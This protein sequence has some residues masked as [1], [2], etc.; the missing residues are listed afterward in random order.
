MLAAVVWA[1]T[2][3]WLNRRVARASRRPAGPG[4]DGRFVALAFDRVVP[5]PD[6]KHLDRATLRSQFS[7]LADAGWQPVTLAE[8][9]AA[10]RGDGRL[11]AK[12][13]LLTFD[14]GYLATY[15]AVDPILRERRWPAVMFLRTDRQEHRDVSFLFWDRLRRMAQSGLWEIASG[16]PPPP[17]RT[18]PEAP[19]GAALIGSRLGIPSAPAWAPRGTEPLVACAC[20]EEKLARGG[21]PWLGFVDDPVGAN[22]PEASPFRIA[23]LRV[24]PL[25]T[26]DDLLHRA[27]V[28]VADATPDAT[29]TVWV[30][31]EGLIEAEGGVVRL[32]GQPRTDI[33][34]PAARWSDDWRLDAEVRVIRGEFW[35][36][37]PGAVPGREWRFGGVS[38]ALYVQDRSDGRPPEVLAKSD[39]F[40]VA[41]G[42]HVVSVVKRGQGISVTWDGRP[43]SPS[44]VALPTRWRG[45]V[46]L[47]GYGGDSGASMI[48][49]RLV[50]TPYPYHVQVVPSAPDAGD[51]A[52]WTQAASEIA[53]LSPP[54]A[55]IDG[56][57]VRE[58]GF[59]RDLFRILGRR[60][61]W[62]IVP[63][64]AI[65]GGAGPD[66]SAAAWLH[67]LPDRIA[68]EGWAGL[69]VDLRGVPREAAVR[70]EAA[71]RELGSHLR[72]AHRRLVVVAS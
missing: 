55:S 32:T 1:G 65:H 23:R 66:G 56:A 50:L 17:D 37:Q 70:W 63:T 29:G 19:P 40:G 49:S 11:P 68:A 26:K 28:A 5:L 44:P 6:G 34:I 13:I 52:L 45:R 46:G 61:A 33:W 47:V 25:W 53:A 24:D 38:G 27:E 60:Y 4:A 9:Q 36:A 7:A 10:Y 59:D 20:P 16:D 21:V 14:E 72:R 35:V 42:V 57:G 30:R 15:E 41:D 58:A 67:G 22:D 12:P 8:V 51:V 18:P 54:W 71:T 31:G 64:I 69:R 2:S 3:A 62:D 43:F 48:V 39:A